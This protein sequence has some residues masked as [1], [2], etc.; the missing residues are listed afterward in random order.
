[1]RPGAPRPPGRTLPACQR[2]RSNVR[3]LSPSAPHGCQEHLNQR[4]LAGA[5]LAYD[6]Y[7]FALT[8]AGLP[9]GTGAPHTPDSRAHRFYGSC[10]V[11]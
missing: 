8:R 6:G 2:A 5:V 3:P 11:S 9:P 7:L 10:I 4:G 1:M